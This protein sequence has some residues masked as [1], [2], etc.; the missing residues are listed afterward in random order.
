MYKPKK[1]VSPWRKTNVEQGPLLRAQRE[2]PEG[3]DKKQ[4]AVFVVRY[5]FRGKN[6]TRINTTCGG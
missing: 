1:N 4:N 6:S 3:Y 2:G 5:M